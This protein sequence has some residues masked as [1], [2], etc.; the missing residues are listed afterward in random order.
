[1]N[2]A[3][4]ELGR[5]DAARLLIGRPFRRLQRFLNVTVPQFDTIRDSLIPWG[6]V[7]GF[8]GLELRDTPS[9]RHSSHP[10]RW[11]GSFRPGIYSL[12]S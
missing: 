7:A 4:K 8:A 10:G 3:K 2:L 9:G 6:V 1:M 12:D 11:S 5:I